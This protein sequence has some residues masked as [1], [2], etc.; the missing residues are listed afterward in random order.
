MSVLDELEWVTRARPDDHGD[1]VIPE[2]GL[3]S[4]TIDAVERRLGVPLPAD[5]RT[6]LGVCHGVRGLAWEIDFTGSLSFEMTALFPHGLPIVGDHAGNFW[7][8]DCT[9]TPEA[10]AAIFFAC[11]DPPVM[12]WQ[13]RG[14]ATL[15][16]ELRRTFTTAEPSSLDDVH[17]D[18]LHRVWATNPG[19]LDRR[20]AL[21]GP[22]ETL[23]TFARSLTDGWSIV[24]LRAAAP[25]MGFS[26]G[27]HGSRTR[28]VRDG[29]HRVFACAPPERRPGVLARLFGR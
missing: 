1:V 17:E 24:D 29:D 10:E 5:L 4:A 12:L 22:D 6:L 16:R 8:V 26:W 2:P 18:R 11:H 20:A 14:M 28:L 15:L 21:D 13:C 19:I 25:G 3:D 9:A 27:R 7:V 23:R